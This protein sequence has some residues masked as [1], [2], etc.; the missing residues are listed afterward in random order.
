M[1]IRLP[2]CAVVGNSF[3][4]QVAA[5]LVDRHPRLASRL[6]LVAPTIDSRLRRWAMPRLLPARSDP[7]RQ[8][9]VAPRSSPLRLLQRLLIP[10]FDLEGPPSL[11]RLIVNEY[12]LAGPLRVLSTYRWALVDDLAARMAA[13][14]VP[15]LVAR[16]S[17]DS[18]VSPAWASQLARRA[19]EG[20]DLEI[21]GVDH[22]AGYNAPATLA[23]ALA[24]FLRNECPVP[25]G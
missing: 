11:R 1:S 4:T 6:A 24:P 5:A 9:L 2:T 7:P 15:V 18:L 13:V 3:G 12:A 8:F 10:P 23:Q 20:G 25:V 17:R 19:S 16:G 22:D 14:E 21:A